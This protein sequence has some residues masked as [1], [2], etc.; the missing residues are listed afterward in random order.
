MFIFN[1]QMVNPNKGRYSWEVIDCTWDYDRDCIGIVW[2]DNVDEAYERAIVLFK[3]QSKCIEI[4][5][6][7]QMN[8]VSRVKSSKILC[9]HL[10]QRSA[11]V[12]VGVPYNIASYALFNHLM[13]R[14]SGIEPGIFAHT[15]VDAHIYTVKPDGS[16]AEFDHVPG[17]RQQLTRLPRKLPN[18][19]IS[20]KIRDLEDLEKFFHPS[21]STDE[22]MSHFIIEN[23]NPH[24]HIPFQVAV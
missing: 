3:N 20:D 11:D 12:C 13:A 21:V 16:N 22:I 7:T 14:F 2:A 6:R 4:R 17:A 24:P 1:V 10:T 23:Y 8:E 9:L 15:L 19:I 5:N 18:L